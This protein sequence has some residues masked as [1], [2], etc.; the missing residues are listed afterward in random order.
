MENRAQNESAI[1]LLQR[2]NQATPY[3]GLNQFSYEAMQGLLN[4]GSAVDDRHHNR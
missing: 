4:L 2:L 1:E 3:G